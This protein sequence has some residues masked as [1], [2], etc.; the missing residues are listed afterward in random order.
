MLCKEQS[1]ALDHDFLS[2]ADGKIVPQGIYDIEM[3]MSC[4][5]IGTSNDTAMVVC[6]NIARGS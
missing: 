3:N 2:F 5:T 1:K 6:D 4:L